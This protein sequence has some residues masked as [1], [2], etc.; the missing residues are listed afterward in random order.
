[1]ASAAFASPIVRSEQPEVD[2]PSNLSRRNAMTLGVDKT[3]SSYVDGQRDVS[4]RWG[5]GNG[6]FTTCPTTL[7]PLVMNCTVAPLEQ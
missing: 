7:S 1:M 6:G 2:T 5:R 4:R 3:S